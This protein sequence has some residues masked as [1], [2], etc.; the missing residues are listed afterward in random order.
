MADDEAALAALKAA[1]NNYALRL[2]EISENP[3]LSYSEAG[4]SYSWTEYQ[5][6]LL[7]AIDKLEER[8]DRYE[9]PG[10]ESTFTII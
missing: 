4:I 3:Q 2:Q 10:E 9:G 1:R 6:F 7:D 5:A 8:I